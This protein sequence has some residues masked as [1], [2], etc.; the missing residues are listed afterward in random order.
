MR[1]TDLRQARPVRGQQRRFATQMHLQGTAGHVR[2]DCRKEAKLRLRHRRGAGEREAHRPRIGCLPLCGWPWPRPW[3]A[4]WRGWW[5]R[6]S[7]WRLRRRCRRG[8]GRHGGGGRS[9]RRTR[10]RCRGHGP[11]RGRSCGRAGDHR[12]HIWPAGLRGR[13]RCPLRH[14]TQGRGSRGGRDAHRLARGANGL[15][16][17]AGNRVSI[18]CGRPR[19]LRRVCRGRGFARLRSCRLRRRRCDSHGF[20]GRSLG[21][22][23]SSDG[24]CRWC[25]RRPC[26]LDC[27]R[28]QGGGVISRGWTFAVRRFGRGACRRCRNR[29]CG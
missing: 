17:G 1:R 8:R 7:R 18:R 9:S 3:R 10:R 19:A 20:G 28:R 12:S 4:A 27:S 13:W 11:G 14:R 23:S 21:H 29:C 6:C 22:R 2:R 16:H 26:G 25:G 24:I 15:A 5:N